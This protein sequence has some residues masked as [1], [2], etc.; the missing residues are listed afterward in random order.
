MKPLAMVTTMYL[1]AMKVLIVEI[2]SMSNPLL[3]KSWAGFGCLCL[4][5]SS[6]SSLQVH[7]ENQIPIHF[8]SCSDAPMVKVQIEGAEY[9][10]LLDLGANVHLILKERVLEKL[11]H[12]ESIGTSQRFDFQGNRYVQPEFM[13]ESYRLGNITVKNPTAGE[14]SLFFLTTGSKLIASGNN[15]RVTQQIAQIEGIVGSKF[16][17]SSGRPCFLDMSHS[18][19]S[20]GE[21]LSELGEIYPLTGFIQKRLEIENGLLCVTLETNYGEKKFLIDTGAER[22]AIRRSPSDPRRIKLSL[23][24]FGSWKF[25]TVQFPEEIPPLD[26]ILGID[27]LKKHPMFLDFLNLTIYIK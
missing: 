2:K 8:L 11:H 24:H 18:I 27:F 5:F 9:V 6:C 4:F 20:V 7:D 10:L 13:L 16:F 23:E 17:L 21:T 14:E 3:S 12:K 15:R 1:F 19:L 26:G 25:Y 22:S